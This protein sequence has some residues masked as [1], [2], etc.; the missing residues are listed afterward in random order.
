MS[1]FKYFNSQWNWFTSNLA[2]KATYARKQILVTN[3]VKFHYVLTMYTK[4]SSCV[5]VKNSML[6]ADVKNHAQIVL[7]HVDILRDVK[8][9]MRITC[10]KLAYNVYT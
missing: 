9:I 7:K 5:L 2:L 8:N 1:R 3:N 10:D 6:K 4:M